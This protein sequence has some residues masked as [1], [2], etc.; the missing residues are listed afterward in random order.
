[1][2]RGRPVATGPFHEQLRA[3]DRGRDRIPGDRQLGVD[4]AGKIGAGSD[5]GDE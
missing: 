5:A 3:G 4:G 2:I 1:M